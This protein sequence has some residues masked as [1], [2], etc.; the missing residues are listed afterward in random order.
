MTECDF[1]ALYRGQL[2]QGGCLNQKF[3]ETMAGFKKNLSKSLT[4]FDNLTKQWIRSDIKC[5]I[6][7]IAFASLQDGA[8][9]LNL[10]SALHFKNNSAR[11][12]LYWVHWPLTRKHTHGTG[13][14]CVFVCLWLIAVCTFPPQYEA[15]RWSDA[16]NF[17]DAFRQTFSQVCRVINGVR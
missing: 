6:C 16:S 8:D 13:R 1:C 12:E 15:S 3:T 5:E 10:K 14:V 17:A 7:L 9:S 11:L 4:T 2:Q